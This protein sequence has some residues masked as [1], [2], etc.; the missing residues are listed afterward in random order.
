MLQAA[1]AQTG[2]I[3]DAKST[4]LDNGMQVIV[5]ENHRTPVVTHMVWY[6][7][8]GAD[9]P[10]G[11]SGLAHFLEHLMFKGTETVPSGEFSKRVKSWGG[12]DN[13]FTSWDFTAYFQTV[14]K[15][16]LNDVMTMEADRMINLNFDDEDALT[17]RDVIV[18]ERKQR[19]DSN[20]SAQLSESMRAALFV[21]HPYARPIIGWDHELQKLSPKGGREF[22]K[23]HYGPDNAILIVAGDV[24][25]EDVFTMAAQ[26]YGVIETGKTEP[27]PQWPEVPFTYGQALVTHQHSSVQ[28]PVWRRLYRLPGA[29]QNYDDYLAF[30]VLEDM[31]GGNTGELYQALV[32]DQ[33]LASAV[34]FGYGGV[35]IG[36]S[37]LSVAIIPREDITMD[38]IADAY[39]KVLQDFVAEEITPAMVQKSVSRLQD[40]SVYERDS[41]T[42]PAM[43]IGYQ[44]ISGLD[45]D[46]VENW[47][48]AL[49][50][51]SVDQVKA[52]VK[53]Y[54]LA[55]SP[56]NSSVTGYLLPKNTVQQ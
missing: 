19:T 7:I 45:L 48:N 27:R 18:Q 21:N 30:A 26:H 51:V 28:Q 24:K 22:Y 55:T 2:K 37:T 20:P 47:A 34:Q 14:P 29:K 12:N 11:Q 16:K 4:V 8:G 53:K 32:V 10:M 46:Q 56:E 25:A 42:G 43:M 9:E 41:L 13:A 40:E 17:E 49:A 39:E 52:L 23:A 38:Q 44:V 5:V 36:D 15:D 33:E 35:S 3:Y 6:R 50:Q 54:L 1:H 31:L